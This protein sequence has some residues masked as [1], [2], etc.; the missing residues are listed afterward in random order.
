MI[1]ITS[2]HIPAQPDTA[3]I[4]QEPTVV[5][6]I[7]RFHDLIC[8]NATTFVHTTALPPSQPAVQ[9]TDVKTLQAIAEEY[10]AWIRH[11]A[12]GH[13]YDDFLAKRLAAAPEEHGAT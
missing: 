13:S 2:K 9:Q 10:N 12:A 4:C 5:D 6:H 11:H 3:K 7:Q 1:G 8:A